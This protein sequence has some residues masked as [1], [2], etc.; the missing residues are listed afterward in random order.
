V[1]RIGI[2]QLANKRTIFGGVKAFI[3]YHR[4]QPPMMRAR[5]E[6]PGAHH[7]YMLRDNRELDACD[8]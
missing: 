2:T 7:C 5:V 1:D 3:K 8:H 4:A 6:P